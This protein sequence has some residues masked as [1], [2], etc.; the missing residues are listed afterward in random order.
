MNKIKELG[1][2]FTPLNIVEMMLDH[3]QYNSSIILKKHIIDNSCGDGAFLIEIVKRYCAEYYKYNKTYDGIEYELQTYIH[4]IEIDYKNWE[5]CLANLNELVCELGIKD[6]KWDIINNDSLNI[7]KY[8]NKMDYVVGNPPYVRVHN[9]KDKFTT[10]KSMKFSNIGMTDLFIVFYEIGIKMLN[11]HG[12]LSYITP[13]SIVNSKAG[14]SFRKYIIKNQMLESFINLKHMQPFAGITTYTG[15]FT[16]I[17]NFNQSKVK[18]YEY[19]NNNLNLISTLEASDFFIN[20]IFY[21]G[22][23]RILNKLKKILNYDLTQDQFNISVKNGLATLLDNV[24]IRDL[25]DFKS[26]NIIPIFK[27]STNK[28]KHAIFPYNDNGDLIK[29]KELDI[30]VQNYLLQHKSQLEKRSIDKNMPWYAYGRS[31]GLKDVYKPK[32]IINTLLK[33]VKDIKLNNINSGS[34]IY[35][36]LYILGN[37]TVENLRTILNEDFIKYVQLLGKYKN[38]GYYTFSSN[39]LKKFLIYSLNEKVK[40]Y[41]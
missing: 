24:F 14:L 17:K 38:G 12:L 40:W 18:Y 23:K 25:F 27:G 31:Q 41:E 13:S 7:S 26:Q 6:I 1:K 15:I 39:D 34:G 8:D 5:N 29:F 2:V 28:Q 36:G 16:L 10:V 11:D 35:S 37:V 32:I 30:N 3:I 4:G 21:F 22:D 20:E 9:L 33:N 19:H